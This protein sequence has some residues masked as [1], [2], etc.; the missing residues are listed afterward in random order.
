MSITKQ[1]LFEQFEGSWSKLFAALQAA[2]DTAREEGLSA[3]EVATALGGFHE[4]M[5][6]AAAQEGFE[7]SMDRDNS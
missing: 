7:N 3:A 4:D 6:E 2:I 5:L 1:A